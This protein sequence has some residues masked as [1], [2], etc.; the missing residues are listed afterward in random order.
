M[1]EA[2]FVYLKTRF[3]NEPNS[4]L[5]I[6]E[7]IEYW[8]YYTAITESA[9]NTTTYNVPIELFKSWDKT[10]NASIKNLGYFQQEYYR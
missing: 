7:A 5:H 6:G 4:K 10:L 1:Q 3:D 2:L 8:L 9:L